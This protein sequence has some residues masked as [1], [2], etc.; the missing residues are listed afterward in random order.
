MVMD[1]NSIFIYQMQCLWTSRS[2]TQVL[3]RHEDVID[4]GLATAFI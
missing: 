3:Y 2:V 4:N 1:M